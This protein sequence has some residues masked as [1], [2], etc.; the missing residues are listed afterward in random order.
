MQIHELN[1]KIEVY[2][3]FIFLFNKIKSLTCVFF[4]DEQT[5][6]QR[7]YSSRK[8]SRVCS[9]D[10]NVSR[11]FCSRPMCHVCSAHNQ[12]VV[13]V[14]LTTNVSRVFCSRPMCRVCS[15]HHQCAVCFLLTT[16]VTLLEQ[17]LLT[18]FK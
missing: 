10:T 17:S 15:A 16:N 14:Q 4:Y 9:A 7:W 1:K 11:V 5:L 2:N 13:C 3:L 12:C 8:M 6:T 18:L